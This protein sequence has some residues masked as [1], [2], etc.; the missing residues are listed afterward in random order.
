MS[1]SV[2]GFLLRKLQEN[3]VLRCFWDPVVFVCTLYYEVRL[4]RHMIEAYLYNM[5]ADAECARLRQQQRSVVGGPC[6]ACF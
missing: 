5:G 4:A 2:S 3:Y 6:A 1:N